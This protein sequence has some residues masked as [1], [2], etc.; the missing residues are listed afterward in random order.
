MMATCDECGKHE[1][2]PYQ[3]QRCGS[4]FCAE[5][6]LPENHDCPGLNGWD[7]P[8]GVFDS[9]F[10]DSVNNPGGQSTSSK[11]LSKLDEIGGPLG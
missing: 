7:D 1:N 10:D 4:T 6:R 3:C 5:H 2:L 8:A 11:V 9:G